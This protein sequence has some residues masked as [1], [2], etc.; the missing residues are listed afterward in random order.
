[1][2]V[3]RIGTS[4]WSYPDWALKFYP[5]KLKAQARLAF[6][7]LQFSTVEVNNTFYRIPEQKTLLN[8]CRQT[9]EDFIF[10]LKVNR[11][12][13][14]HSG[15]HRPGAHLPS[16]LTPAELI[17][18]LAQNAAVLNQ[19]LGPLLFQFPPQHG[20]DIQR[21]TDL[22]AE[23]P[24]SQQCSFEFRNSSWYDDAVFALLAQHNYALVVHDHHDGPSPVLKTA[25]WVY[26]R[27]HGPDGRYQ[28]AYSRTQ[29][30]A[31]AARMVDLNPEKPSW[32]FFNNTIAAHAV[33]NAF[34]MR[35]II[36]LS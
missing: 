18:L 33:E 21:L 16:A 25:D 9:P 36:N 19:K 28:Q 29:L 24:P 20:K 27:L 14:H 35:T 11:E 26:V 1:M 3:Y 7:S 5:Y 4:G 13:T 2:A 12:I 8:W 23:L 17:A 6:Y 15:A 30:E 31:W 32:L 34:E 10:S 22:L